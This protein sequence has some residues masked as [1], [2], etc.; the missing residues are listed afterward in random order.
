MYR[1]SLFMPCINMYRRPRFY[2][3]LPLFCHF[4]FSFF[5]LLMALL[6][7]PFFFLCIAVCLSLL[8]IINISYHYAFYRHHYYGSLLPQQLLTLFLP[9]DIAPT[10]Y[11]QT[12]TNV[13]LLLPT[14]RH[15]GPLLGAADG[16]ADR[17]RHHVHRL[18]H[19]RLLHRHPQV[20]H[21]PALVQPSEGHCHR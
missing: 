6:L 12:I 9:L 10:S 14:S 20:R 21:R 13:P 16:G 5:F 3:C 7:S 1:H 8:C 4:C 19:T 17:A 18:L 11:L 15:R 2:I